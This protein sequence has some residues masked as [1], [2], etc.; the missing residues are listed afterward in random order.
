VTEVKIMGRCLG[1]PEMFIEKPPSD[2][3][4]DRT[5]EDN[6]GFSYEALDTYIL[7]GFC[8]DAG[9]KAL[10]DRRHKANL[11]KLRPMPEYV[12]DAKE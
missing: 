10:M 5:D 4:T 11:F 12:F 1:L 9:I 7:T 8:A 6:F 3:L 2:G